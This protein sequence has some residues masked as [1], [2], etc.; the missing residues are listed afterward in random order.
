[1]VVSIRELVNIQISTF[2]FYSKLSQMAKILANVAIDINSDSTMRSIRIEDN[3]LGFYFIF[4]HF[5]LIFSY[6]FIFY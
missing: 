3:R 5:S 6:F 1:M 2:A 4:F